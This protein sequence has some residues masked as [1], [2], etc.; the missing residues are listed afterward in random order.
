MGMAGSASQEC[1]AGLGLQLVEGLVNA[2]DARKLHHSGRQ[3]RG[4]LATIEFPSG[5]EDFPRVLAGVNV[6]GNGSQPD[7][8]APEHS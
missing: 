5:P 7:D 1:G 3:P 8:F 2:R 4:T 6:Q